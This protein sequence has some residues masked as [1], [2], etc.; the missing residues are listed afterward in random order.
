MKTK[1][2]NLNKKLEN[3]LKTEHVNI[4]KKDNFQFH[5]P[6]KKSIKSKKIYK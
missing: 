1:Y 2:Q 4:P 5:E 6:I 3:L